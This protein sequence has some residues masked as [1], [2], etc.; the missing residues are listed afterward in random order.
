MEVSLGELK[1][2]WRESHLCLQCAHHA[3]CQVSR[4]IDPDLLQ[5]VSSCLA[6]AQEA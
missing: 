2:A 5:A 1:R 6:Y 4:S 3:V